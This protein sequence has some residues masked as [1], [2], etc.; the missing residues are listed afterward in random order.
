MIIQAVL[1]YCLIF[2]A[3]RFQQHLRPVLCPAITLRRTGRICG[4]PVAEHTAYY[5][6]LRR[7][8][9]CFP[10]LD[11]VCSCQGCFIFLLLLGRNP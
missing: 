8:P 9:V 7:F 10:T 11:T 3:K 6:H 5:M 1:F 2:F 4:S